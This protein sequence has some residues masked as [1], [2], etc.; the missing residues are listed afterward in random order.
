MTRLVWVVVVATIGCASQRSTVAER[1]P[2]REGEV[3]VIAGA[4]L[5]G[6]TR[7]GSFYEFQL[8]ARSRS[9][10]HRHPGPEFFYVVEGRASVC[11]DDGRV[12]HIAAGDGRYIPANVPHIDVNEEAVPVKVVVF[13]LLKPGEPPGFRAEE[14]DQHAR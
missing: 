1:V 3:R 7:K 6:G 12:D 11:Y 9:D 5:D 14:T 4:A 2:L 10:H 13:L 8:P